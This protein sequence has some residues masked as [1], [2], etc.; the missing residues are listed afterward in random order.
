MKYIILSTEQANSVRGRHGDHSYL[1]PFFIKKG[2][3]DIAYGLPIE[4]LN[5]S[6][7]SDVH[8]FLSKCSI[9]DDWDI[10]EQTEE[11]TN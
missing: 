1:E 11:Q 3:S 4:V 5:D 2:D 10:V 7:Y 9:E 6:E 8:E